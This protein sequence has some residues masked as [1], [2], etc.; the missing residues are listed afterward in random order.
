VE[1]VAREII[2]TLR[3]RPVF[4]MD[5]VREYR[6][7]PYRTLLLAWGVVRERYRLSRDDDGRYFLPAEDQP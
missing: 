7:T 1:S 5:L 6:E 2:V 3:A 4:F